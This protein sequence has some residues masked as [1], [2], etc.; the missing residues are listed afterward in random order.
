M[1]KRLWKHGERSHAFICMD[2]Q[3]RSAMACGHRRIRDEESGM[4]ILGLMLCF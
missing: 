1:V 4:P 3:M 2:V